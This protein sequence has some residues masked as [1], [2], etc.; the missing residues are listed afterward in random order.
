MTTSEQLSRCSRTSLIIGVAAAIGCAIGAAFDWSQF[1]RAYLYVWLFLV[2]LSI[3]SLALVMIHHLTGGAWGLLIRKLAE[4][5]M[6]LLPLAAVLSIP[7]V[8]GLRQIYPWANVSLNTPQNA[9]SHYWQHYLEPGFFYLRSA[10]YFVVWI[11]LAEFMQ[12]SSRRIDAAPTARTVWRAYKVS[13]FGLVLLGITIHF[14]AMDWIMS[15]QPGFTSTIFGPLIF[16]NQ[17]LAAFT[18]CILL[19]YRL[20]LRPDFEYVLSSKAVSDLAS[21]ALTLL[22]LWAYLSWFQFM[23]IWM[24]DLPHGNIWYLI[25]WRSG[26]GV[27]GAVLLLFQ[28]VIPFFLLL[29][30]ALK[31]NRAT[32]SAIAGLV[33]FGQFL[34]MYFQVAP[35]L[36]P[37]GWSHHWIDLLTPFALGGIWFACLTRLLARGSL[38][39]AHDLNYEQ[40]FILHTIDLEE[41]ERTE[42]ISHD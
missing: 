8:V 39:P 12:F 20:I 29:V 31:Q 25:R 3:G 35:L 32:L 24:A 4:R 13:G 42:A 36:G 1:L 27:V 15:L 23:L 14:A 26:W 17:I 34:F 30:R 11:A 22:T 9:S 37:S 18:L 5:Q 40:A 41:L 7:L 19:Y 2:G 6:S 33:L 16:A 38:L 28:F 10:T 21:L